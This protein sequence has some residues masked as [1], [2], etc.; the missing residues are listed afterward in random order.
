MHTVSMYKQRVSKDLGISL[1]NFLIQVCVL[2]E[3]SGLGK[4]R[5]T[6]ERERVTGDI[7]AVLDEGVLETELGITSKLHRLR[8]LKIISEHK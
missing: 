3:S 5:P 1:I 8:L 4:Y 2:L 6:I 7:L